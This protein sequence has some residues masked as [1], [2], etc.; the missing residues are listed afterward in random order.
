MLESQRDLKIQL[1]EA[2]KT[3]VKNPSETNLK[4]MFAI[5]A[6]LNSLLTHIAEQSIRFYNR[7]Y[8]NLVLNKK[9]DSQCISAIKDADGK[10]KTEAENTNNVF[11]QYYN[12]L[13]KREQ[14]VSS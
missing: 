3:Y 1:S 8:M 10:R 2:D 13:Y 6:S 7:S 9:S 4:T 14:S 12:Q 11:E 5:K